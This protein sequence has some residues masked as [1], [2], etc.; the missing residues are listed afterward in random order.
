MR[1]SHAANTWH[2]VVARWA[3][4]SETEP[5]AAGVLTFESVDGSRTFSLTPFSDDADASLGGGW[6]PF[7][8][9]QGYPPSAPEAPD[10]PFLLVVRAVAEDDRGRDD[11]RCWLGEEHGPRQTTI[12]GVRWLLAYEQEGSEHSFLNLWGIDDPAVVGG[13]VWAQV[14]RSPWWN[15]VAHVAANADRGVYRRGGWLSD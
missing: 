4:A 15:R 9:S 2:R 13:E 11:F 14:R 7:R 5:P 8:H 6:F 1:N 10:A 12:P 3:Q